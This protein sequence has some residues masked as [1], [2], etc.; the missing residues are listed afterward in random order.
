MTT[1][2]AVLADVHADAGALWEALGQ[3]D[4]LGCERIVCAGDLIDYG[5]SPDE[6]VRLVRERELPCVRGNHDRWAVEPVRASSSGPDGDR[7][8]GSGVLEVTPAS[9]GF[10]A[11][12]PRIWSDTIDGVRLAVCHGTPRSDMHGIFPE[13]VSLD[14]ARCWL[15]QVRAEVL[16]VGHTHRAFGLRALGGGLIANPGALLR[17]E[18]ARGGPVLAGEGT[19]GVLE[20]PSGHFSVHRASDGVEIEIPRLTVGIRDRRG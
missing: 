9:R 17:A 5:P 6:V 14:D 8:P 18:A 16:L 20:L 4:R 1:R 15:E 10:L 3:I 2:L 13:E 12:L 19:F 11:E 7:D